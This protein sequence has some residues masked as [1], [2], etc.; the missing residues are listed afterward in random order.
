M[1]RKIFSLSLTLLLGLFSWNATAQVTVTG[2]A[3]QDLTYGTL[4]AA[5]A[6]IGTSQ[7]G[8]TI[9]IA[10]SASTS[11]TASVAIG[12]GTWTSLTIYPSTDADVTISGSV[13]TGSLI[14]LTGANN[15]TIDG[16]YNKTG[17]SRLI[18]NNTNA[19]SSTISFKTNAQSNTVKYCTI[20]GGQSTALGIVSFAADGTIANGNGLNTIDHN[21]ITNNGG[22]VL[23]GVYA[24]GGSATNANVGNHITNNEFK[25]LFAAGVA[26]Q[27]ILIQGGAS[28]VQNDNYTISDNSF[29]QA[30]YTSTGGGL[31]Q[32]IAISGTVTGGH[33]ISG[34]FIGGSSA[35][36]NGMF[37]KYSSAANFTAILATVS[38]G[39]TTSI[40]GNKIQ[41]ISWQN[42]ATGNFIGISV[43]GAGNANIGTV[44]GNSFGDNTT[45]GSIVYSST[46]AVGAFTGINISATGTVDCQNNMIGSMKAYST[47]SGNATTVIGITKTGAGTCTISN[48]II[49]STSM[50]NSIYAYYLNGITESAVAAAQ[51]VFVIQFLG[52]GTGT[53]ENNTVANITNSTTTGS[54]HGIYAGSVTSTVTI[55]GNLIHSLGITGYTGTGAVNG[56]LTLGG[57]SS[58]N[59]ATVTN[60]IIKLGDTN[61]YVLNGINDA[62]NSANTSIY[63]NTVYITGAPTSGTFRSACLWSG[64]TANT[65]NYRNNVLVNTRSNDGGGATGKHYALFVNTKPAGGSLTVDYNDYISSGASGAVLGYYAG[66][67]A[68]LPIVTQ[69]TP[70]AYAAGLDANSI[71]ENPSFANAGGTTAESYVPSY[72]S[73]TGVNLSSTVPYDY[74]AFSRSITPTMGAF[75]YVAIWNG[76]AWSTISPTTNYNAR[77]D[78]N[79]TGAGFD[80]RNLVL[81]AGK[82]LSITSG[83]LA[84]ANNFSILSDAVN[85]TGTFTN[86]GILTV[87]GTTTVQ[88]YLA[89]TRNWYM[90]SPVSGAIAPAGYTYYQRDEAYNSGAGSWTSKPFVADSLFLRGHGY[91]ALPTTAGSTISFTGTLNTGNVPIYLTK[92]GTGFNL[93]GNPYPSHLSWTN[94]FVNANSALIESSIYVRTNTGGTS[95]NTGTWSFQTY[96]ASTGEAVPTHSLL[97]GGIIPPMQA[98][99]IKAKATGTLTMDANLTK[100]HQAANP[101]KAPA[102]KN[103]DRQRVR[104][105]VSNGTRTDETLLFFDENAENGYDRYDSPK[106][107]EANSEV[108]IYT[109][110]G[111]EKLIMNGL[112]T[113]PL[114]QE[115]SLGFVPGSALAF[116]I[117]ANETSNLP[118]DVRV[119]LK[120]NA[121][122]GMETDLT[123][124]ITSYSFN[125]AENTTNRFSLIFRAPDVATDIDNGAKINAQV[126]VNAANQITIIAPEKSNY[127][128]YNAVGQLMENGTVNS[129]LQTAN[130]KLVF[131][132]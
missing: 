43:S 3:S 97:S 30:S 68:S 99:W 37:Y 119:I 11:E 104:L 112:K 58:T 53:I 5:I 18:F 48:N 71:N 90:S 91:I 98:F 17:T 114:N 25:N 113:M 40:Q 116:S 57:V 35:G 31:R 72:L 16:R 54:L 59:T 38:A 89:T 36:C 23:Y 109:S 120:D 49:G 79:F 69:T 14:A 20:K 88:Q 77:I 61:A 86:T 50:A 44:T 82:Q 108:Q 27:Q 105:E 101:L 107:E 73:L 67:V 102:V 106:F 85:G 83:T 115:I 60:N 41:N 45:T 70:T 10:I 128:I 12:A 125:A 92:S 103:T 75:D 123:D 15:V 56:I 127:K 55:N 94:T 121:N 6:A 84:V 100:S 52:T 122:N 81:S 24:I 126:F 110:V 42:G 13:A 19:G 39:Y 80:A 78:G 22:T 66:D 4:G 87:G 124:G 63:H 62:A 9:E 95:N 96:N 65:R 7:L 26:T 131:M 28:A 93:I 8:R 47:A 34:N 2:S 130:C 132:W 51:N 129:K 74:Y 46:A 1:K 118:S 111:N 32:M 117:K 33:T 29:Y 76:S 64:G 21:T